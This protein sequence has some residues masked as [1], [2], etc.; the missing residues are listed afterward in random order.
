MNGNVITAVFWITAI[1]LFAC[2][3]VASITEPFFRALGD[4][5]RNPIRN[6]DTSGEWFQGHS[7][8]LLCRPLGGLICILAWFQTSNA[9]WLFGVAAGASFLT[10]SI[11]DAVLATRR[12]VREWRKAKAF[13]GIPAELYVTRKKEPLA[14]RPLRQNGYS[15]AGVMGLPFCLIEWFWKHELVFLVG[16]GFFAGILFP[17]IFARWKRN[18]NHPVERVT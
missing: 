5:G 6:E 4:A 8:S 11:T 12:D 3:L 2:F 1:D 10:W 14:S 16:A 17:S 9:S 13:E 15:R 18:R 7:R